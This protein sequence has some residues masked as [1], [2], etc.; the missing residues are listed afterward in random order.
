MHFLKYT[1]V[2]VGIIF[3]VIAMLAVYNSWTIQGVQKPIK[4]LRPFAHCTN[5]FDNQGL[6]GFNFKPRIVLILIHHTTKM[7]GNIWPLII[8]KLYSRTELNLD[9]E[10]IFWNIYIYFC[11]HF[12]NYFDIFMKI[13]TWLRGR[14]CVV[15]H[16]FS[17]TAL[18]VLILID[19]L[20]TCY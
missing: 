5:K 18:L 13:W 20:F 2:W 4:R 12:N 7:A 15:G 9:V 8:S 6:F 3:K 14:H 17:K 11:E 10:I 1:I 19:Y 16:F